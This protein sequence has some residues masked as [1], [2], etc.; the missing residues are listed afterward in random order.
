MND[1]IDKLHRAIWGYIDCWKVDATG[2]WWEADLSMDIGLAWSESLV[3][4][5]Q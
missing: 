4:K 2:P 5:R 3:S 1:S